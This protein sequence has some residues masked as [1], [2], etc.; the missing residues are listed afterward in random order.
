[1]YTDKRKRSRVASG[2]IPG[3]LLCSGKEIPI[4]LV[5][6]SLNGALVKSSRPVPEDAR[7]TLI[8]PL[9]D[10][11]A[12]KAECHIVRASE[13]NIAIS[14]DGIDP[15][16]YPHLHRLVQLHAP[17]PDCIDSELTCPLK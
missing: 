9:S 12:I 7:C 8:I 13:K 14:F 15:D 1:M 16:S 17:D 6:I 11:A 5:N 10:T 4:I 2:N 3:R